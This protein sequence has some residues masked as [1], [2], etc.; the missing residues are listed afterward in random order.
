MPPDR[1]HLIDSLPPIERTRLL[2]VCEPVLL[3]LGDVLCECGAAARH[4][5]FPSS[6]FISLVARVERHAGLE[7]GLVGREGMLGTPLLLGLDVSPVRA[8]V[9]CRGESWRVAAPALRRELAA[10]EALRD[11]LLRYIH[12]LMTQLVTAAGCMRYHPIVQR[13]ARWLLMGQDRAGSDRFHVT[14][15]LLAGLLGVRRV[16]ITI[17]AG[18]LQRQGLIRYHRGELSVLDRA[19]LEA[20]ACPCYAGDRLLYARYLA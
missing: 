17:A 11:H 12:V 7:V 5:Y 8:Q 14:H 18:A 20:A 1:N 15:E 9:Q 16:G 19:G 6:G 4:A 2:A 10:S 3:V 13:L